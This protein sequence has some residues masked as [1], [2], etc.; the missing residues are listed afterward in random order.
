MFKFQAV[1]LWAPSVIKN[2]N[3]LRFFEHKFSPLFSLSKSNIVHNSWPGS[4]CIEY[5]SIS[6]PYV[7]TQKNSPQCWIIF[8]TN[9]FYR[10]G[11]NDQRFNEEKWKG[12]FFINK[13]CAAKRN[14]ILW[15]WA[16]KWNL[17]NM[18]TWKNEKMCKH[19]QIPIAVRVCFEL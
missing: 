13:F 14:S 19:K 4:K 7:C 11:N 6:S 1:N 12:I 3:L 8:D 17:V 16:Q 2:L 18:L 9:M 10:M 5:H 15:I